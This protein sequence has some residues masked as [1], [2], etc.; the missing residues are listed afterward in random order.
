MCSR[1][2]QGHASKPS[3]GESV[4]AA[5]YCCLLTSPAGAP[6]TTGAAYQVCQDAEQVQAPPDSYS[7]FLPLGPHGNWPP[8]KTTADQACTTSP[9][10]PQ[11]QELTAT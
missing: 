4:A 11:A 8:R 6:H 10:A 2:R 3:S 9:T 7:M 1:Q 5:V